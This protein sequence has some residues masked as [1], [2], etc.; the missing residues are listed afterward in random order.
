MLVCTMELRRTMIASCSVIL[1]AVSAP[2]GSLTAQPRA[3]ASGPG[4]QPGRPTAAPA[5]ILEDLRNFSAAMGQVRAGADPAT[6]L[7]THYFDRASP[8]LRAFIGRRRMT[9]ETLAAQIAARPRFYAT[10]ADLWAQP[11]RPLKAIEDALAGLRRLYPQTQS[12]PVYL[13]VGDFSAGGLADP[14]GALLSV[15]FYS[16]GTSADLSEL[17]ATRSSLRKLD[18]IGY[19]AAHE[20]I[21]I[22]QAIAQGV[23]R[24]RRLYDGSGTLLQWAIREGSADFLAELAAGGHTNPAAH[25]FGSAHEAEIWSKFQAAKASTQTDDWMGSG[26]RRGWPAAIG[27]FVGYRIAQ[28]YYRR[29][30][31]RQQAVRDMLTIPDEEAFLAASGY[32]GAPAGR[33]VA[34]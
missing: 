10:L 31:D 6:A 23:D 14:A 7:Q 28:A 19:L 34:K 20:M 32:D 29:S 4:A 27:Y 9:A 24:Y 16:E 26:K 30:A 12:V 21:H 15:E 22:Q 11:A 1:L 3:T 17:G 2:V 33:I 5:V 25:A 8:G 18:E 13:F